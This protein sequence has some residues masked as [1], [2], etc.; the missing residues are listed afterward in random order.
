[1]NDNV[2]VLVQ[3]SAGLERVDPFDHFFLITIRELVRNQVK[4]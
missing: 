1:M 3:Q 4:Y 2:I